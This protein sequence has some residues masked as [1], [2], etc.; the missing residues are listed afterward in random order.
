MSELAKE[1]DYVHVRVELCVIVIIEILVDYFVHVALSV[2]DEIGNVGL[3]YLI[4][5]GLCKVKGSE[6]FILHGVSVS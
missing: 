6:R 4:E 2:M 5:V 1:V 3:G